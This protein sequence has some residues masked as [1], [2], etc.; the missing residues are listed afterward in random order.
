MA[1]NGGKCRSGASV[2]GERTE[3]CDRHKLHA[4]TMYPANRNY[5][6]TGVKAAKRIVARCLF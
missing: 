5:L 2:A 3:Q 1:D 6:F 4:I